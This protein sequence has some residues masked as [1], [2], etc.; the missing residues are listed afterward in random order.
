MKYVNLEGKL[1]STEINALFKD[2]VSNLKYLDE[3]ILTVFLRLIANDNPAKIAFCKL[4]PNAVMTPHPS[5]N[6]SELLSLL[7]M[8]YP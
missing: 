8:I 4:A 6:N 3:D 1:L 2:L 7:L 5:H